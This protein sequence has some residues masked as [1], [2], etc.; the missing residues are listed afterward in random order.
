MFVPARLTQDR[1]SNLRVDILRCSMK[2]S[3]EAYVKF[4]R[5]VHT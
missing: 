4:A 3:R 2:N 1:N 5:L